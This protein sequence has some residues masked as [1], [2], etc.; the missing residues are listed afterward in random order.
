MSKLT[1]SVRILTF[2]LLGAVL[3]LMPARAMATKELVNLPSGYEGFPVGTILIHA[4][5]RNLYVTVG[6]N[7]A[8]RYRVAVPKAGKEW[9]GE[10]VVGRMEVNPSWIAPAAV[11]KDHP[12]FAGREIPGGAPNNPMGSRAIVL[13]DTNFVSQVA[14]HGT[15]RKMRSSIGTAASYGCIRML[16]EDVEDLYER[17]QVGSQVIML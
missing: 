10:T 5:A 16:N 3:F 13:Q 15:T 12:E 8:V 4:Q 1:N 14:I 11:V 7:Q 2:A 9:R 17:I 6:K